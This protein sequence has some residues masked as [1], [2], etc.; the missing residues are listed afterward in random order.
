MGVLTDHLMAANVNAL[1]Y[2]RVYEAI[3]KGGRKLTPME[4]NARKAWRTLFDNIKRLMEHKM[5]CKT[6][7]DGKKTAI[8][9][10]DINKRLNGHDQK[11]AICVLAKSI[12]DGGDVQVK[13]HRHTTVVA[14]RRL[15]ASGGAT[16]VGNKAMEGDDE[17]I[18]GV[19]EEMDGE[20]MD[21]KEMDG[22][23]VVTEDMD[24]EDMDGEDMDGEDMDGDEVV[25]EEM[26]G[27]EVC[28]GSYLVYNTPESAD[29]ATVVFVANGEC[30]M[31]SVTDKVDDVEAGDCRLREG[32][33]E[34][35]MGSSVYVAS[36]HN[37]QWVYG[38]ADTGNRIYSTMSMTPLKT[39]CRDEAFKPECYMEAFPNDALHP[40]VVG[41]MANSPARGA[42][43]TLESEEHCT[44]AEV[45]NGNHDV[46]FE[47]DIPE[48]L[49]PIELRAMRV[50]VNQQEVGIKMHEG[51]AWGGVGDD[52]ARAECIYD[53]LQNEDVTVKGLYLWYNVPGDDFDVIKPLNA[54]ELFMH[55]EHGA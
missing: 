34:A 23:E 37:I 32:E 51:A 30:F 2:R 28:S 22:D 39:G 35:R 55:I 13:N 50:R 9:M 6:G 29:R 45:T 21:G 15:K 10:E 14:S 25:T 40:D 17:D 3:P 52:E 7:G 33:L 16:E 4:N 42:F 48:G 24:G 43:K 36:L 8:S 44:M 20:E 11:A 47:L 18:G 19:T 5:K 49:M 1:A 54:K 31:V 12:A 26:D 53:M 41:A 38:G 46:Y 27:E